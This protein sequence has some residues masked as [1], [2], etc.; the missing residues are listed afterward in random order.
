MANPPIP[1]KLVYMPMLAGHYETDRNYED[2]AVAMCLFGT[3]RAVTVGLPKVIFPSTLR[4][5]D[6]TV[7]TLQPFRESH[8]DKTSCIGIVILPSLQ[9]YRR[10]SEAL[11]AQL[12]LQARLSDDLWVR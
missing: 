9:R 11:D 5:D 8:G 6:I 12:F 2:F 10:S 1:R 3:L 7:G 4:L